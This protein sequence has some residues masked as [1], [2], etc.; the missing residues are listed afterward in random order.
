M[1]PLV[2]ASTI[3]SSSTAAGGASPS[4]ENI[5]GSDFAD[6][7][8][9]VAEIRRSG[10][11]ALDRAIDSSY[12]DK[13]VDE[14]QFGSYLVNSNAMG[15]VCAGNQRFLSHCL[16]ASKRAYDI[17]TARHVLDICRNYFDGPFKLTN[18][19]IYQTHSEGHMPW[20]TDNN[21]Q[22]GYELT[23]KHQ[24]QGLL[25]LIYLSD[26]TEN[27]FQVL[28]DS[29]EWSKNHT[30]NYFSDDDIEANHG[31]EIVT[32]QSPRGSLFVCDIHTVHRAKPF[33]DRDYQRITLLFQVDAVSPDY[34]THGERLMVNP[35][36]VDR[37]DSDLLD[38]LGFGWPADY[39]TFPQTSPATMSPRDL[40]ALQRG[41]W[42][43]A[44][45][46]LLRALLKALIPG[47]LLINIK[48]WKWRM[49]QGKAAGKGPTSHHG[50]DP[51]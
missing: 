39:P 24:L 35:A 18:Q 29:H 44:I 5:F 46:A 3:R 13:L 48:R 19:R 27:P 23:G 45:R 15:V 43:L 12:V 16:A 7:A 34:P 30:E 6:S 31:S 28:R 9:I 33:R 38:Y 21:C 37:R 14:I 32:F 2:S 4:P 50:D 10:Y 11:W 36:F 1:D 25:F 49:S 17:I 51:C 8:E 22:S 42:P 40:W 26:V 47:S 41:L 20:H